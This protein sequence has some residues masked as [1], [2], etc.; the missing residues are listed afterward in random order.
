MKE[1]LARWGSGS[2]KAP[3]LFLKR[4]WRCVSLVGTVPTCGCHCQMCPL[5]RPYLRF[6]CCSVV[7]GGSPLY[8]LPVGFC[9]EGAPE[10]TGWQEVGLT[11]STGSLEPPA[12]PQQSPSPQRQQLTSNPSSPVPCRPS[13]AAPAKVPT[14]PR[15]AF[16]G[17]P[18]PQTPSLSLWV[19][20]TSSP[21]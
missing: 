4:W 13:L 2:W 14:A 5:L 7:L 12:S 21:Y 1:T 20:I 6:W 15:A 10:G 17:A 9:Q 11:A 16:S 3:V 19:L 8:H 18:A